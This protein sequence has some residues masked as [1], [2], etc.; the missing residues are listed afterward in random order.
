MKMNVKMIVKMKLIQ[1]PVPRVW[2]PLLLFLRASAFFFSSEVRA[3]PISSS[4][5]PNIALTTLFFIDHHAIV[6]IWIFDVKCLDYKVSSGFLS[7][8]VVTHDTQN[9]KWTRI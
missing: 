1:N 3:T 8:N 4:F 2:R 7:Y 5:V 9:N 6:Y